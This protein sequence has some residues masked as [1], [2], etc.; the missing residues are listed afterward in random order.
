LL[1]EEAFE[2]VF[3]EPFDV[4]VVDIES[5]GPELL[6][7]TH[8]LNKLGVPEIIVKSNLEEY[9]ELLRLVGATR[10]VNSDRE[11]ANRVTPLVLSS[12][13]TNF[14][15]ISGDLVLAEVIAPDF[16]INRTV[17]ESDLRRVHHVNVVAVKYASEMQSQE[18]K[19]AIF[20]DLDTKYQFK[21]GDVL[22][23]TGRESDVF[24]FAGIP[25]SI[26]HEKDR[27]TAMSLLKNFISKRKQDNTK[28]SIFSTS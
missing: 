9:E 17:I 7:V 19:D 20:H 22:L 23:V 13:L 3:P 18:S 5:N 1:D 15:P 25:R 11:A 21:K 24:A 16:V 14:M 28:N 12:S 26:E 10:I 2:R 27:P 8:R 6:L 4:A